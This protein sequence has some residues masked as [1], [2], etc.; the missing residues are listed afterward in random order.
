MSK[1]YVQYGC[2][3]GPVADGWEHF[4]ASPTLK[5]AQLPVVGS[6]ITRG[7]VKFDSKVLFGDITKG[8]PIAPASCDGV[9][10]SHVL[11]HLALSDAQAALRNTYTVLKPDGIFRL[12]LPDLTRLA[13]SYLE[14]QDQQAS[15]DFMRQSYLGLEERPRGVSGAVRSWFGNSSHL[16]MWDY[17]SLAAA[18]ADV[19]FRDIR[20]AQLGDSS[21]PAFSA[22]ELPERWEGELGIECRR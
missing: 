3:P 16:W 1:Y 13:R 8:L 12:V 22:V 11:E 7:E 2:G 15:H 5:L 20:R 6:V 14:Q 17:E 10:C 4:D 21:D 18:L 9:Y 19:G